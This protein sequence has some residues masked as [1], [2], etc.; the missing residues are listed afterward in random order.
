MGNVLPCPAGTFVLSPIVGWRE[1]EGG[2]WDAERRWGEG[3]WK[4]KN[5]G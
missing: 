2:E 1:G 5:D 4:M 3:K